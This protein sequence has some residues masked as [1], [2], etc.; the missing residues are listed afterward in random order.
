MNPP[1]FALKWLGTASSRRAAFR[2]RSL[3]LSRVPVG[4]PN[5]ADQTSETETLAKE[6]GHDDGYADV[7]RRGFSGWAYDR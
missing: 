2:E 7:C 5:Q 1:E 4:A 3:R 6:T